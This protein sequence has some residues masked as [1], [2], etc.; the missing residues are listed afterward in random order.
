MHS[1]KRAL[2]ARRERRRLSRATLPWAELE[3]E[4][5]RQ[6]CSS[7]DVFF[8]RAGRDVPGLPVPDIGSPP[9]DDQ[10]PTR[11]DTVTSQRQLP[12]DIWGRTPQQRRASYD[13]W[14]REPLPA[15]PPEA[16]RD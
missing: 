9:E 3:A 7:A 1:I 14:G 12:R 13:S 11:S 6:G 8:D 4:A 2:H 10:A 15:R 16:R 5:I